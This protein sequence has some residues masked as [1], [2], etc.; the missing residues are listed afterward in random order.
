M[1]IAW[2]HVYACVSYIHTA[3]TCTYICAKADSQRPGPECPA[4]GL[5]QVQ[6]CPVRTRAQPRCTRTC[7]VCFYG[8]TH[9]H[10]LHMQT[11]THTPHMCDASC[12]VA[13]SPR[14]SPLHCSSASCYPRPCLQWPLGHC[15]LPAP[16][17]V[18][19]RGQRGAQVWA[20]VGGG[21][22]PTVE[23]PS[24]A[25]QAWLSPSPAQSPGVAFQTT[26]SQIADSQVCFWGNA[27]GAGAHPLAS[28]QSRSHTPRRVPE[29]TVTREHLLGAGPESGHLALLPPFIPSSTR[30]A[31]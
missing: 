16:G 26:C 13:I 20:P 1:H 21:S 18:T 30:E 12:Q 17:C 27:R 14:T 22:V 3:W 24:T 19:L 2:T 15:A 4:P 5:R 10:W 23:R 11:H 29:R 8:S 7:H 25:H 31:A 9:W 28:E 6:T